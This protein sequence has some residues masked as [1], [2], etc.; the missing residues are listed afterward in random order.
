MLLF[1]C[2]S[3]QRPW[4][5]EHRQCI[6][7]KNKVPSKINRDLTNLIV[8][9]THFLLNLKPCKINDLIQRNTISKQARP[10]G[11]DVHINIIRHELSHAFRFV[12]VI[13]KVE[14]LMIFRFSQ[15]SPIKIL[16]WISTSAHPN[17]IFRSN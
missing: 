10:F 4:P 14:E 13:R 8:Q 12:S 15:K 17:A 9:R 1:N 3:D 2:S 7:L 11:L 5:A 16:R 6:W